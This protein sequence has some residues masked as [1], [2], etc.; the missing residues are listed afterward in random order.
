VASPGH[1]FRE[2]GRRAE[3]IIHSR[4]TKTFLIDWCYPNPKKPDGKE[5][6][7]LLVVF[8]DTAVIWQIKD[9]KVD[10]AG[11]YKQAEVEKN[12]RQLGGARRAMFDLK[13][14]IQLENPRRGK[15]L[16]NPDQISTV[17]LISVLIGESEEPFPFFQTVKDKLIHVFTRTFADLAL[18]ESDTVSDF[19]DYLRRRRPSTGTRGLW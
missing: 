4:A 7:D 11:R 6:C 17:H 18:S 10:G 1:Y 2:K 5:L 8:D 16:F 15:E 3:A 13:V 19:C 12:L 14:P 9:L